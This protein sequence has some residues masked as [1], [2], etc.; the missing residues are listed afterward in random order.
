MKYLFLILLTTAFSCQRNV[1]KAAD[2]VKPTSTDSIPK[3]RYLKI[4][5][6]PANKLESNIQTL[7]LQYT[8]WG[9]AC[10][11]WIEVTDAAR[12]RDSGFLAHHIFIEPANADLNFE[13]SFFQFEKE[14]IVVTGQFYEKEDYPQGTVKLEESLAKAKVFR[15]T[16]IRFVKKPAL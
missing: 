7:E 13:D 5:S 4:I 16:K 2:T 6:D 14:N 3:N 1:G 12:F 8:L 11:D 15:Y 10:A 9:C